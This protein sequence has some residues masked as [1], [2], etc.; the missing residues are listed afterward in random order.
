MRRSYLISGVVQGVG[1]RYFTGREG[2]RIGVK[3][4]VRNLDG[5]RVEALAE[6][7]PGQLEE[8]EQVIKR[9]PPGA[10]VTEL[11]VT[12]KSDE[13]ELYMTFEIR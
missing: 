7:S 11:H 13:V 10:S 1:F 3:G 8:F 4:W 5:G 12:E 6:G 2:R 9:G